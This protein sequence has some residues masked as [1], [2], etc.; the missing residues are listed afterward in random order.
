[1]A[2]TDP[3]RF[4]IQKP[5]PVELDRLLMKLTTFQVHYVSWGVHQLFQGLFWVEGA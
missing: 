3:V 2:G 4:P 5:S 1:M